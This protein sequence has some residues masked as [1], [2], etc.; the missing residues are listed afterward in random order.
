MLKSKENNKIDG[1]L[2]TNYSKKKAA[3]P[4]ADL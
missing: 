4:V 2:F 1:Y 3:L